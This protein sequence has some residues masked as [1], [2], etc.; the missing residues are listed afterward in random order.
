MT[1]T[2]Y[3]VTKDLKFAGTD[4]LKNYILG[5]GQDPVRIAIENGRD[6]RTPVLLS[7]Y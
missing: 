7:R 2:N 3:T 5:C 4:R 1:Y 6:T